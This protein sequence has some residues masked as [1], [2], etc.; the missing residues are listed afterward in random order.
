MNFWNNHPVRAVNHRGFN[1]VAPENTI[2][3]YRLSKEN[4]FLF[5]EC[6]VSF[7]SDNVPVL[8]HDD[9]INRTSNG[10]GKVSNWTFEALRQL[11]FGSWVFL[12]GL[13]VQFV[14]HVLYKAVVVHNRGIYR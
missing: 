6:D 3:A 1:K 14:S 2:S 9:T 13:S 10:K 7:T 12:A 5:V 4:G 8:L 11:D